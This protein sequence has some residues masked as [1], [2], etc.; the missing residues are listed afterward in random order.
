MFTLGANGLANPRDFLTPVAWFE[1]RRPSDGYTVI[2]KFQG[3]LFSA[4]QVIIWANIVHEPV[5]SV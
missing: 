4:K 3:A 5:S 2:S 1:D